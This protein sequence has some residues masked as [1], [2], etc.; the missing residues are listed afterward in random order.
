[1]GL[2]EKIMDFFDERYFR[3]VDTPG[4]KSTVPSN[5]KEFL[6][7]VMKKPVPDYATN[8]MYCLGGLA[9]TAF[10]MQI[11]TGILLGM[12]YKP[13]PEEAYNSVKFIMQEVYMGSLIRSMHAWG[14]N[15]F[16]AAIVLHTFRI[17][18][19]GSYKKP[20]ELTWVLGV[21]VLGLSLFTG[22]T[23][24][25]LPW[26]QLSYWATT[27]GLQIAGTVPVV[28]E[29]I[30]QLLQGGTTIGPN[31]LSRFYVLHIVVLPLAIFSILGIKFLMIRRQG[32]S[33]GF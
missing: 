24:Y 11:V 18:Y 10:L 19:T 4:W 13:T 32:I 33:G 29:T 17:F 14:S 16:I 27:V 6:E 2:M 31:T 20:R 12:Y 15:I 28:G 7:G 8:P 22:F 30:V 23:G 1:M 3:Y 26:D 5:M 25:L 21:S 9:F